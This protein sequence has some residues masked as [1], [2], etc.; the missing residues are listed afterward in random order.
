MPYNP[1]MWKD[2]RTCG[3]E[4]DIQPSISANITFVPKDIRE[5]QIERYLHTLVSRLKD[6]EVARI[7]LDVWRQT[8]PFA[9]VYPVIS[10]G[11]EGQVLIAWDKH[12]HHAEVEIFPDGH[13][14]AFYYNLRSGETWDADISMPL[15]ASP[16]VD[17]LRRLEE[18]GC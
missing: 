2:E 13:V 6:S 1:G 5:Q 11:A 4:P 18:A 8:K 7:A 3:T 12:E 16:L 10:V 9:P 15:T 17:Y 14:E